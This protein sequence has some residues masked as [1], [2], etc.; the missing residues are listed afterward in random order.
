MRSDIGTPFERT[1][2]GKEIEINDLNLRVTRSLKDQIDP[3]RRGVIC[4]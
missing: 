1:I 4:A 2:F 3:K